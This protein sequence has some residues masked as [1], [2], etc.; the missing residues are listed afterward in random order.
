MK[1]VE[2]YYWKMRE[3]IYIKIFRVE[4]YQGKWVPNPKFVGKKC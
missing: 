2:Y 3:F 4:Y 1:Y